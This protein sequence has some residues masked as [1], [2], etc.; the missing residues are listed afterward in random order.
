MPSR[1]EQR[2][3][4]HVL[5]IDVHTDTSSA[6]VRSLFAKVFK[7]DVGRLEMMRQRVANDYATTLAVYQAMRCHD[8]LGVVPPVACYPDLLAMVTEEV[9]AATLLDHLTSAAT[10]WSG[11]RRNET[12]GVL[13]NVGRWIHA[14]QGADHFSGRRD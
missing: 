14:F 6:P 3:F 12:N 7:A 8:D 1:Y 4:S 2:P 9:R 10:W 13:E 5:R 11:V